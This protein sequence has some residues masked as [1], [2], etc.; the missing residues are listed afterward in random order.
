MYLLVSL[1]I[2]FRVALVGRSSPLYTSAPSAFEARV[3]HGPPRRSS[4]T[5][6]IYII[7]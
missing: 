7:I 5:L 6:F 3:D 4:F 1:S 2:R